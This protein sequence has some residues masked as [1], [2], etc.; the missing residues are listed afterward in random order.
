MTRSR[1]LP[2]PRDGTFPARPRPAGVR[3]SALSA[4][5][6]ASAG[7]GLLLAIGTLRV[8]EPASVDL[9]MAARSVQL[10]VSDRSPAQRLLV[11]NAEGRAVVSAPGTLT[12]SGV[13]FVAT[14]LSPGGQYDLSV[15]QGESEPPRWWRA[16]GSGFRPRSGC[17]V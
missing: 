6:V 11:R 16:P 14:G 2:H 8:T 17:S 4:L 9:D 5:L 1:G 13:S 12:A 3:R 7:I 15:V 10:L